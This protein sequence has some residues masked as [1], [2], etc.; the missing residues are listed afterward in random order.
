MRKFIEQLE[1][2]EL[3]DSVYEMIIEFMLDLDFDSL[4]D[5]Q[6][7]MYNEIMEEL[8]GDED[9][10]WEDEDYDDEDADLNEAFR[11]LKKTSP[12]EKA[13]RKRLYRKNKAKI[14]MA[15]KKRRKSA[16]F[17]RYQKKAKR[18]AKQGKTSTGKLQTRRS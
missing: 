5:D 14:K 7:D 4:T 12:A 3:D 8:F 18:M 11:K 16:S 15:A 17:K 10:W 13:K 2:E 9:P 6:Q 1:E